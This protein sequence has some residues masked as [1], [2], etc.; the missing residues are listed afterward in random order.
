[1]IWNYDEIARLL[2]LYVMFLNLVTLVITNGETTWGYW[3]LQ[4]SRKFKH[5]SWNYNWLLSKV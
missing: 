3:E 1:M 5:R 2:S 4:I